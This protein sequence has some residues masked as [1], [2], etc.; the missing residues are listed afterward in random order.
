MALV[1]IKDELTRDFDVQLTASHKNRA[2][3]IL[4]EQFPAYTGVFLDVEKMIVDGMSVTDIEKILLDYYAD[5]D[6]NYKSVD[7]KTDSRTGRIII[8]MQFENEG[9]KI[10]F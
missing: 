4:K 7:V 6:V 10:E 2:Y 5:F 1:D 8:E 9:V 3:N